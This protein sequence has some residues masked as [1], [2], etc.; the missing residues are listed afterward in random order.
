M[1]LLNYRFSLFIRLKSKNR[2]INIKK[3]LF[4]NKKT[5]NESKIPLKENLFTYAKIVE[6]TT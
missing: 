5:K 4:I 1:R 3:S 2:A 6:N